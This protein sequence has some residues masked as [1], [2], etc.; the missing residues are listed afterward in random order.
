MEVRLRTVMGVGIRRKTRTST[1]IS[2]ERKKKK[3][4]VKRQDRPALVKAEPQTERGE[5]Q[6]A[7]KGN[8]NLNGGAR[9]R[10]SMAPT[11]GKEPSLEKN[12]TPNSKKKNKQDVAKTCTSSTQNSTRMRQRGAKAAVR[13]ENTRGVRGCAI[14]RKRP[15]QEGGTAQGQISRGGGRAPRRCRLLVYFHLQQ[16]MCEE[17]SK[18]TFKT[19]PDQIGKKLLAL[20]DIPSIGYFF[21]TIRE[22]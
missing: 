21:I 2:G 6:E 19:L 22:K 4:R 10:R 3:P 7:S 16:N 11:E 13:F 12:G 20:G 15:L 14:K 5:K 1:R 9:S 18:A 8:E 17:R